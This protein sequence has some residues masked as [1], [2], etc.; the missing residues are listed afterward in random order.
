M[1]FVLSW[2]KLGRH[3]LDVLQSVLKFTE[4]FKDLQTYCL[5]RNK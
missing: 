4:G 1:Q 2:G 3:L 5:G